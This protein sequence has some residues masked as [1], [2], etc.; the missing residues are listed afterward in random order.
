MNERI[1]GSVA[2]ILNETEL[3]LNRGAKHGVEIGMRFK[4]LHAA[5]TDIRDPET[6]EVIGSVENPKVEV[7][8]VSVQ[9]GL[10]VGRTF[11][12]I[13]VP[14][15]GT[16]GFRDTFDYVSLVAGTYVPEHQR[17]ETLRSDEPYAQKPLHEDDS[18]VQRGDRAVQVVESRT[19]KEL[20]ERSER[21]EEGN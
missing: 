18:I 20:R 6:D 3:V 11:R 14:A 13:H 9:D 19:A 8:I 10:S 12:T 4:V 2:A 21:L 17:I 5:G 7:K 16:R 15:S 1:T